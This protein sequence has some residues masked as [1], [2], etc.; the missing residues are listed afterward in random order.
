MARKAIDEVAASDL[1]DLEDGIIK[2]RCFSCGNKQQVI[3]KIGWNERGDPINTKTK[4][5]VCTNPECFRFLNL[6]KVQSWVA[7]DEIIPNMQ[8]LGATR[9]GTLE[10]S[11]M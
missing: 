5:G 7:D 6:K 2:S 4:M 10:Y 8:Q 3:K 9:S 11:P 1:S